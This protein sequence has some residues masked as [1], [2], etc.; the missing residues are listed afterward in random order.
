V[1]AAALSALAW[2]LLNIA[3]AGRPRALHSG[4]AIVVFGAEATPDGPSPELR[5]RLDYAAELFRRGLAPTVLCCGGHSGEISEAA[6]MAGFLLA[7]GLPASAVL[8]DE[9]CPSTRAALA[10]TR[11]LG[12]GCWGTVLLVS[13]P[14]HLYR[15][16]SEA[17]RCGI[18]A[19]ACPTERTPVMVRLRPRLRQLLR[20]A[21]A[22]W[23]YAATRFVGTRAAA[24]ASDAVA[25]VTQRRELRPA[26]GAVPDAPSNVQGL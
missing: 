8:A 14:Y 24:P 16:M 25:A 13:S 4:G 3:L 15:I 23:W 10:A 2:T 7:S 20:E 21:V 17:R 1:G 26:L 22:V 19:L 9:A 5:A 12:A 11:R 6:A 18:S